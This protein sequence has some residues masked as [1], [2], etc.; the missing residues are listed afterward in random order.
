[1]VL[2]ATGTG[3]VLLELGAVLL[4][5]AVVCR[6]AN[7]V[8]LSPTPFYLLAGLALGEGGVVD[9]GPT[10]EFIEVI[11]AAGI[12]LTMLPFDG[13]RSWS[14]RLLRLTESSPFV[15]PFGAGLPGEV[16]SLA[17]RTRFDFVFL[18]QEFLAPLAP[19][20]RP[21]RISTTRVA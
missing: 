17:A 19:L 21:S 8:G 2:A 16:A 7:R 6:V 4:V 15:R 14:A 10:R 3:E 1:M 13:D 12:A 9:L 18:N 5:L 11:E 20:I